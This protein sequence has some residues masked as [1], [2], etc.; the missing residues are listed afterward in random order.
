MPPSLQEIVRRLSNHYGRPK[1]PKV[2]DPFEMILWENVAYLLDDERRAKAFDT[3]RKKVGTTPERIAVAPRETLLEVARLGG[4][5]PEK[6]VDRLRFI[7]ELTVSE[8]QGDLRQAL[9]LPLPRAKKALKLFPSIGD[10]GAEKILL[11]TGTAPI[12]AL[13]SNG[14]RVL[15]RLGYG[16]ERKNYSATYRSVQ[17]A[18]AG[19]TGSD[20]G[21]LV[22]AHQLLRQHGKELCRTA[23]PA[24]SSCPLVTGCGYG[25]A[26]RDVAGG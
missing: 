21:F 9:K 15:V 12:L 19:Q 16:A 22:E 18:L 10:P 6:R 13:E 24:C 25:R 26:S 17:E 8:F 7:A 5:F 4:M 14:L 1:P 11:F 2:T 3:L 23:Q 20:C